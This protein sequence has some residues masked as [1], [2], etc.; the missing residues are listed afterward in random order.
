[1]SRKKFIAILVGI[2][3]AIE[4]YGDCKAQTACVRKKLT[5]FR[6]KL[7]NGL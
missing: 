7:I 2:L 5:A 3:K 1:M 6:L 4:I